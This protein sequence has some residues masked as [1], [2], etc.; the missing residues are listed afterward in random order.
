MKKIKVSAPGKLMLLGEHSVVHKH[1]CIVTAVEQRLYLNMHIIKDDI[2]ILNAPDVKVKN[3]KKPFNKLLQNDIPKGALYIETA[4]K[5]FSDEYKIDTGISIS[6]NSE[7][8]SKLGFGSS[9]ASAVCTIKALAEIFGIKITPRQV[10]N[11]AYKTHFDIRGLSSGFDIA[12]AVYGKTLFYSKRGEIIK[13]IDVESLP[14]IIGYTKTKAHTAD[15]VEKVAEKLEKYP[16][17][18]N[19]IFDSISYLVQKGKKALLDYDLKL[20]GDL[21]NFNQGYLESLGVNSLILSKLVYAARNSGAFGAKLSGAGI[22]DNMIAVAPKSK[23]NQI[24]NAILNAG[25]EPIKIKTNV[26][27]VRLEN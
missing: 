4:V 19:S 24:E 25:G 10:F 3:Y 16:N 22:G 6:T 14:L 27:G 8:S 11:L 18:V 1:P 15:I 17:V 20:F 26:E 13:K 2:L 12:A 5:N 7:F 21:M 23:M 9:S